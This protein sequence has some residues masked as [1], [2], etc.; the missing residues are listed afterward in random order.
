[1][2]G[3]FDSN[4]LQHLQKL[5]IYNYESETNDMIHFFRRHAATLIEI[6]F[7]WMTLLGDDWSS[8][9]TRLRDVKFLRLKHFILNDCDDNEVD[10]EVQDYVLWK[11]D[12][13]P[14][15]EARAMRDILVNT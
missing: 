12:L 6:R 3:A 11:T 1:M 10:L 13:D 4:T 15:V 5:D 14:I 7:G 8:L 2:L 9:L